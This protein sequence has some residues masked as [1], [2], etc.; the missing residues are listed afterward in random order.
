M[1][2]IITPPPS[3]C[4]SGICMQDSVGLILDCWA[5]GMKWWCQMLT[6]YLHQVN[7]ISSVALDSSCTLFN[8]FM[9]F[10]G[11]IPSPVTKWQTTSPIVFIS[12]ICLWPHWML[13]HASMNALTELPVFINLFSNLGIGLTTRQLLTHPP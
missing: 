9:T 4:L 2:I 1:D 8:G 11:Y 3:I 13:D 7:C 6:D 5:F 12:K 10:L